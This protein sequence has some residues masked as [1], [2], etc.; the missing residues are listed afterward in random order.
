M[1]PGPHRQA[2]SLC[3]L[4]EL[5]TGR[6]D[7]LRRPRH[8]LSLQRDAGVELERPPLDLEVVLL[9]ERVDPRLADVAVRSDVVGVDR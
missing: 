6:G 7:P 9:E 2:L 1:R 3:G 5:G 8:E 4:L